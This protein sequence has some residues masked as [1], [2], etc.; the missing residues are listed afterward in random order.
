[1]NTWQLHSWDVKHKPDGTIVFYVHRH[2]GSLLEIPMG[3]DKTS[4]FTVGYKF[5]VIDGEFRGF[6]GYADAQWVPQP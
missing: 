4:A 1:M 2:D 5:E 3:L 6:C